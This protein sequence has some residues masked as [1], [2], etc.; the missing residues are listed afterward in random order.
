MKKTI[1]FLVLGIFIISSQAVFGQT[2]QEKDYI[3]TLDSQ[4]NQAEY[5]LNV[6]KRTFKREK[7][8]ELYELKR[9]YE[10]SR[11]IALQ[12]KR[13]TSTA[14]IENAI[15]EM[16]K[17]QAEI[18]KL[19]G[20]STTP[21]IDKIENDLNDLKEKRRKAILAVYDPEDVPREMGICTKNRRQRAN[22]I[23]REELV[24]EKIESNINQAIVPIGNE[25][26]YKVIFDN[27]YGQQVTFI[28][29]PKDGGQ[30]MSVALQPRSMESHFLIPGDYYVEFIVGGR[31][32][33]SAVNLTIDGEQ[34]WYKSI[35]CYGFVY[36]S[37]Y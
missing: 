33:A 2:S 18:L 30:R 29:I 9:D 27:L 24:L 31:R 7:K 3:A 1:S 16:N 23:R 11:R 14:E 26:G 15:T 34:H 4:I 20:T 8:R 28:V 22:I 37:R 35:P 17:Y 25:G 32:L 13:A 36:K 21:E 6:L 19:E 10:A 5:D 12:K